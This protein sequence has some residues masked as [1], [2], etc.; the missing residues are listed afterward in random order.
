M[1]AHLVAPRREIADRHNPYAREQAM[2]LD[3]E[4]LA[5]ILEAE[6]SRGSRDGAFEP[7]SDFDKL[8]L[9]LA[10]FRVN[11]AQIASDRVLEN[12]HQQLQL[13]FE[14]V[15]SPDQVGILRGHQDSRVGGLFHS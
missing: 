3:S 14:R 10:V 4:R 6:D 9:A 5:K 8:P 15:I 12:G 11:V 2:R 13:A 7:V 1:P